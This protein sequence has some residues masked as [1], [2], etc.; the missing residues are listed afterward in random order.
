MSSSVFAHSSAT[1]PTALP[2]RASSWQ[3]AHS[4]AIC[5]S[6]VAATTGVSTSSGSGA[7]AAA[8]MRMMKSAMRALS[9]SYS[10][11]SVP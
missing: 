8:S 2:R 10:S 9:M 3:I 6:R 11:P 5:A 7:T 1:R 4:D